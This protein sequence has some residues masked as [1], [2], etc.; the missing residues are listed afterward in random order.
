MPKI[1]NMKVCDSNNII[2]LPTTNKKIV[3]E[4]LDNNFTIIME[5]S[6]LFKIGINIVNIWEWM[7]ETFDDLNE[8]QLLE[9]ESNINFADYE[10]YKVY[11]DENE[12]ALISYEDFDKIIAFMRGDLDE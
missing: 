10:K 11:V 8:E 1:D 5:L 9:K 6:K 2:D 3:I 4:F 7:G 12:F